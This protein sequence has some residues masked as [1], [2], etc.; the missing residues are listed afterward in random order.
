[1]ARQRPTASRMPEP[2]PRQLS[3]AGF[4][5]RAAVLVAI[6]LL[7]ALLISTLPGLGEVRDR[8]ANATPG[9]L[10]ALFA[11]ELGSCLSYVVA[12]RGVFCKR[13]GWRFSY[14]IGMAE[15]GTNVL[16][17][18][19]GVGGL[20]L[21]AWA[22]RQGGMSAE[23]IGRRSVAFFVLTSIPNFLCAAVLGCALG[24]GVLPGGGPVVLTRVLG[25]LAVATILLVAFLPRILSRIGPGP[26]GKTGAASRRQRAARLARQGATAVAGG[27]H[28]SGGLLRAR[29][30]YALVGAIGYMALDVLALAAAFAA[31]GTTP[32]AAAFV[33]A[34]V[35]GQLGGLVPLPGGIGG[36]D[37]GL[38]GALT[39]YGSPLSQA[40]AAVLAYRVVQLGIPAV[41]GAAA[42]F[43]LRHT[44]DREDAPAAL[45]EP[46]ERPL[47]VFTLPQR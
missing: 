12:F 7:T 20:A 40:T 30:P 46:I 19:G 18:A 28:D 45:C 39:L 17:P 11:L 38:I 32:P 31:F 10:L 3:A 23:R 6:G 9:W 35:I 1:M 25:G 21:G 44:L 2:L 26:G 37:G 27:V 29:P 43:Q 36:I 47:P 42:F 34:Y 13:L 14:E 16:V 22:L 33:F 5:R 4:A 41:L 15:Q 8:F 24:A